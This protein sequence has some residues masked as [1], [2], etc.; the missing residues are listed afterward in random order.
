MF[1]IEVPSYPLDAHIIWLFVD[2]KVIIY[3]P[4]INIIQMTFDWAAI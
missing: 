1:A 4:T 2:D 3:R